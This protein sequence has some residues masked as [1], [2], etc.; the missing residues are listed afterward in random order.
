MVGIFQTLLM[1]AAEEVTVALVKKNMQFHCD[2]HVSAQLSQHY[3]GS[4]LTNIDGSFFH[5]FK[6]PFYHMFCMFQGVRLFIW[7]EKSGI[8]MCGV[9]H[10][11]QT[12]INV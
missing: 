3:V 7:Q 5:G 10:I 2:S 9:V 1:E 4:L 8:A 12:Y 6:A 11:F